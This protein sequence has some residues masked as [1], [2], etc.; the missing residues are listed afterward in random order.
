MNCA[1]APALA[2][3]FKPAMSKSKNKSKVPPGPFASLQALKDE[4]EKAE[5]S[6]T[7]GA[8]P[9]KPRQDAGRP[10]APPKGAP[11]GEAAD[12][13]FHRLMSGVTPLDQSRARVAKTGD[14]TPVARPP[15][16]VAPPDETMDHLRALVT[17]GSAFEVSDDGRRVEGRR[18]DVPVEFVRRLRRGGFPVD[19]SLDLH[20]LSAGDARERLRA[21]LHDKRARGERC[22]LVIHGKGEGSPGGVGVLRG[23]ISAWLSQGAASVEVAAFATA[24]SADGGEGAVYVLLRR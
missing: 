7:K 4:L 13:D 12:L 1:H 8:A 14:L 20:G 22:V 2:T 24:N 17:E 21:F 19:A 6:K 11:R 23:E 3:S 10:A 18:D 16:R 9:T 15:R 5:A